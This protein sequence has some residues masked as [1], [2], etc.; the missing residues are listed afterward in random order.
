MPNRARAAH[1]AGAAVGDDPADFA[2][3]REQGGGLAADDLEIAVLGGGEVVLRGQLQHLALGDGGG[4]AAEDAQYLER[5]VLDHQ[6]K[7]AGEKE[8]ADQHGGLIAEH[9][10]GAGGPAAQ[11]EFVDHIVMQQRGGV[12]ELDAGGELD[13][14]RRPHSRTI[15]PRR[16]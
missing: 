5:A 7:G 9:G 16:G 1:S 3:G 8:I 6:L 4:G 10:I 11:L 14:P 12:D 13:M 2:G 15:W